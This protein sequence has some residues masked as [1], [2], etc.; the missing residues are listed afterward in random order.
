MT[1]VHAQQFVVDADSHVLE[2]PDLWNNYLEPQYRDRGIY[3]RT[4]S[5][6]LE[7]LIVDQ[8]VLMAGRLA[9]LG[10][11]EHAADELF[12]DPHTPY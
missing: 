9:G 8:E 1:E 2:P 6:N 4:N 11:A 5:D 10:G 12:L 3:F 7:E